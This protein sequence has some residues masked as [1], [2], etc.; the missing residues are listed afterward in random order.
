MGTLS[1]A[2]V[3]LVGPFHDDPSPGAPEGDPQD[4]PSSP[5]KASTLR[6]GVAP[7]QLGSPERPC[8]NVGFARERRSPRETALTETEGAR[9]RRRSGVLRRTVLACGRSA[10]RPVRARVD[11]RG[12]R[13]ARGMSSKKAD[14][15]C[16]F[17][18]IPKGLMGRGF[19]KDARDT[20][21][22]HAEAARQNHCLAFAPCVTVPPLDAKG[23]AAPPVNPAPLFHRC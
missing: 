14:P 18:R 1:L 11:A 4:I 2:V 7:C 12:T 21:A 22:A 3:G 13:G 16:F 15:H 5:G 8:P 10:S 6:K 9:D 17:W 23:S 19:A 20:R